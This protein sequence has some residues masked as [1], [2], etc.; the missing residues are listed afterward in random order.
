MNRGPAQVM[1]MA[2]GTGGHIYPGL[3]VATALRAAG[4]EVRWL[5]ADGGMECSRVPTEGIPLDVVRISGLRGKGLRS[6][7]TGP[8][9]L[10]RAVLDAR[11]IMGRH[12]PHCAVSFGGYVAGPGGIA[13]WLK[14]IPLV[15]HEQNRVPGL[16]NRVLARLAKQVLQAFPGT[17][18]RRVNAST[19]GNPVRGEVAGLE[20]PEIR[21]RE[22]SGPP[23]LLVTGG[24]QGARTLNRMVPAA[25]QLLKADPV[26]EVRHQSGA[27]DEETTRQAY[28]E[29]GMNASVTPFIEDI[30]SAYAW[31]DIVV[32]RAGAL[33]V[34]ELA[35]AG[36]GAI[37]VPFPHAVDDH[38]TANARFLA[39]S[40]AALVLQ[41]RDLTPEVL[42]GQL[43]P[44]LRNRG[45]TLAMAR[46]ARGVAVQDAAQRVAQACLQWV[47]A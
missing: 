12:R 43:G 26:P 22:R 31:A 4:A 9:K 41:E 47:P 25:M 5:G 2:G 10:L 19:C 24:S 14:G 20:A 1:I 44:L 37:L 39:E 23:R 7:L 3:A 29:A 35:A 30:A 28:R 27:H 21:W 46:A 36:L 33:T 42:A 34:S 13:A 6:W 11:R 38:Q 45:R 17:F 8:F 16:T 40:D 18:E 15:V 32:C